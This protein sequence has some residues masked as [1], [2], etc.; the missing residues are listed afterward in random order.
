MI[1][2]LRTE[3]GVVTHPLVHHEEH[4]IK[5]TVVEMPV[6]FCFLQSKALAYFSKVEWF[7][8]N[9]TRTTL[10]LTGSQSNSPLE[11]FYYI[12][13]GSPLQKPLALTCWMR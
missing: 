6:A 2:L 9:G 12:Y 10:V 1:Q 4:A 8:Q 7:E 13:N 5:H 11:H 3:N